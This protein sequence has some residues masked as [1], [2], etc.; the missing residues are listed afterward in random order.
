M[1]GYGPDVSGINGNLDFRVAHGETWAS[2]AGQKRVQPVFILVKDAGSG[3]ADGVYK[4]ASRRWL[5]HDVYENRFGDCIISREAHTN[6][7]NG[8]VKYGFVLGR[9][10]RPLYG[11]KTEKLEVPTAGWKSFEG[12]EPTPEIQKFSSWS[13]CCQH[14]AWYFLQE[15]ENAAGGG[16][17]KVVLVMADRAFDCHTQA[18]P[19]GRGDI[20]EGGSE[21]SQQLC[22][23]LSTR[24]Q[25]LLHL[26]HFKRALIDCCAAVH[27]VPAFEFSKARTRGVTACLNL[28]TSEPQAKLLMD[29]MCRRSDREFPGIHALEPIVDQLLERAKSEKLEPVT[30]VEEEE[31]DERVFYRVVDPEDCKLFSSTAYNSKIIGSR[32][33]GDILRGQ[34]LHKAGTWLELHVSEA[35]DDSF[36]HRRAYVPLFTDDPEDEREEV[37]EKVPVKEF[38][39]H[40]RWELLGLRLKPVGLKPPP[41]AEVPLDYC[42]WVD[43]DPPEN[44]KVWPYIYKHGLAIACML[45]GVSEEVLDSFVRYHWVTGWNHVFLFFDDPDDPSIRHAKSLEDYAHSKKMAG[46][47]LTVHRMDASWWDKAK[48]QSRFYQR[49]EKNDF[50]EGVCK[51]QQADRSAR[52]LIVADQAILEAHDMG[53]DWFA[54]LDIDECIYVPRMQECSARRFFGSK[55]RSI[56]AVRLWNHEAVPEDTECRDWFRECTLFQINRHHCHG[57]RPPRE[58]DSILRQ[59]EGREFEPEQPD[60]DNAWWDRIFGKVYLRRQEAAKRL[61]LNLP[62]SRPDRP[63]LDDLPSNA[64][65]L[66]AFCGFSSYEGGKMIVR[67]NRHLP[68]PIPSN[69]HCWLADNGSMLQEIY[70]ANKS[71]DA[72][73]LH[74]PNAGMQNWRQKYETKSGVSGMSGTG[75]PGVESLTWPSS[76]LPLASSTVLSGG[77][78]RD[79][80]LFYRTFILQNEHNE[81]AYLAEH[82][83]VTRVEIV[84]NILYYYDNPQAPPEQL[85]GQTTWVDP[86]SGLKLGRA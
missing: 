6:P 55:E 42:R 33:Y 29:E 24:A 50:Y 65:M 23:L 27:F 64:G 68:P 80:D 40:G 51:K 13:D 77:S 10:G 41:D 5:D 16:H 57:F 71:D 8:Q 48:L 31:D 46:A 34:S 18:R 86:K 4:P 47:G 19:K 81:L 75:V 44:L 53:I 30:L 72:V 59:R 79:Q 76:R 17:W 69:K 1:V 38:P 2:A 14:G 36:G 63:C 37:L 66:E 45:R 82:G 26:G 52:K 39:R 62:G 74:Y 7:K 61:K 70:Q 25:A 73:I 60:A 54:F 58:Y 43:A 15:A 78:R 3:E 67:L 35:F 21:W 9:G 32:E 83:L 49:Q 28:G 85:P 22:E 20:R 56:E 12:Q 11:V 84:R